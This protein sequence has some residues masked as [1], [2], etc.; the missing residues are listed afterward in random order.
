MGGEEHTKIT[1]DRPHDQKKKG[2]CNI[3]VELVR[4]VTFRPVG[5]TKTKNHL[6]IV[7]ALFGGRHS[8]W[9]RLHTYRGETRAP[10]LINPIQ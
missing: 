1:P 7:N 9:K 3:C 6:N 2:C 5:K 10:W 4:A 8:T